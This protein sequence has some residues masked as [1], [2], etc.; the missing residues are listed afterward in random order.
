VHRGPSRIRADRERGALTTPPVDL[1][2]DERHWDWLGVWDGI[3]NYLITA[4]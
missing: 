3:R 2:L 1:L 4:A